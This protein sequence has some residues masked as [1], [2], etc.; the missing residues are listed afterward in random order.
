[1]PKQFEDKFQAPPLPEPEESEPE[2][3]TLSCRRDD[4]ILAALMEATGKDAESVLAHAL[5]VGIDLIKVESMEELAR[6]Y[7]MRLAGLE[8]RLQVLKDSVQAA[9]G[10]STERPKP[11]MK[12]LWDLLTTEEED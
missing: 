8:A 7:E 11:L 5:Q 10:A 2:M 12:R 3:I 4:P 6:I 9:A 1:M